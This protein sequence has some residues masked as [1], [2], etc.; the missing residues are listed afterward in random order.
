MISSTLCRIEELDIGYSFY[1]ISRC[2]TGV[3]ATV[4]GSVAA[5]F[6]VVGIRIP[7]FIELHPAKTTNSIQIRPNKIA[8]MIFR[9]MKRE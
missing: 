9:P 5:G 3:V 4:C 7:S 2:A 8:K 6:F 1:L